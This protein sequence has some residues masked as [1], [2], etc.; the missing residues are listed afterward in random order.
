ML[1]TEVLVFRYLAAKVLKRHHFFLYGI[2]QMF[3][4][5]CKCKVTGLFSLICRNF[6]YFPSHFLSYVSFFSISFAH[7][8]PISNKIWPLFLVDTNI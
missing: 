1:G 6:L 4:L 8:S 3:Y 7:L 2:F 5:C